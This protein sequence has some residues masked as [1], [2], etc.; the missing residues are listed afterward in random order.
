MIILDTNIVSEPMRLSSDPAVVAWLDRQI[1]ETLYLISVNLAQLLT[2]VEILP[3]GSRRDALQGA[4][5]E[6]IPK[7]FGSRILAFDKEAEVAYASIVSRGRSNGQAICVAD[8]Q[9][10]AVAVAHGYAVAARDATPFVAASV[11]V[12]NPWLATD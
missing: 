8:R 9:V 2:G 6:L 10:V 7:L 11:P 3:A 4:L 1:I 5:E 12:I